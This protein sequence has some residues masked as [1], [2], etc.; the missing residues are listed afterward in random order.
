MMQVLS[1]TCFIHKHQGDGTCPHCAQQIKINELIQ[2]ME[3]KEMEFNYTDISIDE[4]LYLETSRKFSIAY[5]KIGHN[6]SFKRLSSLMMVHPKY[7]CLQILSAFNNL[8]EA[9]TSADK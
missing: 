2:G 3:K 6:V 1:H 8:D 7:E 5:Q 9:K 4:A